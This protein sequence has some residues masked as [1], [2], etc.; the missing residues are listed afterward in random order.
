[1]VASTQITSIEIFAFIADLTFKLL[2]RKVL[3]TNREDNRN[4]QKV[5]YFL[6]K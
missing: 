6:R 5:G 2:S 4:C 1:M 3:F